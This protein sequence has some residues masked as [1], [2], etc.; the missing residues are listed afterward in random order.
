MAAAA[1][2]R[3]AALE[4]PSAASSPRSCRRRRP[5]PCRAAARTPPRPPARPAIGRVKCLISCCCRFLLFAADR[6][7]RVPRTPQGQ[8]T[9]RQRGTCVYSVDR[10][11]SKPHI[12]R[13]ADRTSASRAALLSSMP[14][15]LLPL[16]LLVVLCWLAPCV[17]VSRTVCV[18]EGGKSLMELGES[19]GQQRSARKPFSPCVHRE[20]HCRAHAAALGW[21]LAPCLQGQ[22]PGPKGLVGLRR[23]KA[24]IIAV[25][26]VCR[27]LRLLG[28]T[29]RLE[30]SGKPSVSIPFHTNYAHA[31][32]DRGGRAHNHY[33]AA[34]SVGADHKPDVQCSGG[35]LLPLPLVM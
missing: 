11:M 16:A 26:C 21:A 6:L 27:R 30:H 34:H 1:R 8:K 10:A 4:M 14:R 3:R 32:A 20:K 13:K 31:F 35:L 15:L 23:E 29:C 24:S 33:G 2:E 5:R 28:Y 22:G 18:Q 7:T 9:N 12:D 17:C 19:N 25:V